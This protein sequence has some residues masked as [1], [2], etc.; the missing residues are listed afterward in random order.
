MMRPEKIKNILFDL[1]GVIY[2]I[3]PAQTQKAIEALLTNKDDIHFYSKTRQIEAI[4]LYETGAIETPEFITSV[5]NEFALSAT[6]QQIK[7]A[8][9]A[10]LTGVVEGR[11]QQLERLQK[12]YSLALL[13]NTNSLHF[14]A[15]WEDCQ[16]I[17]TQM[18]RCFFSFKMGMRKPNA[19]IFETVIAEMGW[20]KEETIFVEDSP[21][22]IA[23]AQAVGLPV[24]P[25]HQLSDFDIL[26][27][28][29][30]GGK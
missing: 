24:F 17:Y 22:N 23:G 11:V 6:D 12:H 15:I 14:E 27:D 5:R 10:L 20:K 16:P 3:D 4:S 26:V 18:Q 2:D 7:D 29:L 28:L 8:W 19:D 21:P 13:S 9:N 25:I 30:L 1:G